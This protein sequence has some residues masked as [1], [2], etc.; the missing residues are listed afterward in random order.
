MGGTGAWMWA[1]PPPWSCLWFLSSADVMAPVAAMPYATTISAVTDSRRAV[2]PAIPC[3]QNRRSLVWRRYY[4]R[5]IAEDGAAV[6]GQGP[7]VDERG[8]GRRGLDQERAMQQ[9]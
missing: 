8:C 6:P 5:R 3:L 1:A 4:R 7:G 2:L 9:E